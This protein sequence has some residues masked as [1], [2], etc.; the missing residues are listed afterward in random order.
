M[1]TNATAKPKAPAPPKETIEATI[2]EAEVKILLGNVL[3]QGAWSG[4]LR[5]A[6]TYGHPRSG[7]C[8]GLT[9]SH[10]SLIQNL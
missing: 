10:G 9:V 1:S 4:V 7:I 2:E 6:R 5:H 8:L 3:R